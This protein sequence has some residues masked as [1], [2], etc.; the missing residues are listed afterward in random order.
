MVL[1]RPAAPA[2]LIE[3]RRP[4]RISRS[5]GSGVPRRLVDGPLHDAA[6][7]RVDLVVAGILTEL[8]SDVDRQ[9][10]HHDLGRQWR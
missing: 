2:R 6:D 8:R 4:H 5:P 7:V 1:T 10:L 9:R 3:Q